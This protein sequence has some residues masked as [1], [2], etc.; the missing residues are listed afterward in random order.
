MINFLFKNLSK[1]F[2]LF[3][4]RIGLGKHNYKN[5]K[6][7]NFKQNDFINYKIIKNYVLKNNFVKNA[8]I[9]DVHTFNFLFFYQKLGGK[10][11]IELSK[12]NIFIWFKK[13][14]YYNN[15]PWDN[16]YA[17]KR[18]V[19]LLY[20]YDFICS[21]SSKKEKNQINKILNF[22][23]K[24]ITFELGLKKTDGI[25]SNEI[26]ALLLIECCKK[27]LNSKIVKKIDDLINIQID[28]NSVHK[29]YNILEHAKFLNN[30]IEI[31]NIFFFY[32]IKISQ[33]FNNNILAMTSTLKTYQHSDTSLPL[34]NGC[35]NNYNKVIEQIFE[36]EQFVKTQTLTK[37]KNGIAVSKSSKKVIFFDVVQPSNLG[38]HNEL[39]SGSLAIEISAY[40][41]KIITNCGGSEIGGKNPAYLKYT[42]AHSTIIIDNTNVSEIKE[43]GFN[44]DYVKKVNFE[45]KDD[46]NLQILS[47]THNGYLTNFKKICKRTL[48]IDK[49]RE[50]IRGED[51]IISTKSIVEKNVYHIRFHLMPEISTTLTKNKKNIIIKTKKNIIWLFKSNKEVVIEKSIFVRNDIANET[52]QIVISGVTS[53]LN[54][55]VEWSLEKI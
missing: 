27:S 12:K 8:N 13:F 39:G 21:I 15:F 48:F 23:I 2:H 32:N 43:S 24:R 40:G 18:F 7:L 42:A 9:Q 54:T 52:N 4:L 30:L 29:S 25:S 26:L 31:R 36:N 44:T 5:F 50:I 22:H 14:K 6:D 51:T 11:G 35:N 16:E 41:E 46:E 28:E 10:K 3:F 1:S 38:F 19:N 53:S 17:S 34:F 47:G 45:T 49:K 20:S 55:K 37:F 33:N